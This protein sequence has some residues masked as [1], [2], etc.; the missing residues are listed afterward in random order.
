MS[1]KLEQKRVAVCIADGFEEVE[2][3]EP[4]KALRQAGAEVY[5]VS[6]Q[7]DTVKA[8]RFTDWGDSYEVDIPVD[9][10]E[11][12]DFDALLLPGGVIN[13]DR[14][15]MNTDAVAFIREF[16]GSGKPVAAICHGPQMLIEADAVRERTLTS[17]PSVRKDLINAGANW[18]DKEVVHDRGLITSRSPQDIPAFN[19][20]MLKVFAEAQTNQPLS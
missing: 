11:V 2:F 6:P 14:L 13:P 18:I 1:V 19:E 20:C 15:R 8:W 12:D 10:A 9:E 4:V 5:V 7:E 16:M 17:Y 3:T